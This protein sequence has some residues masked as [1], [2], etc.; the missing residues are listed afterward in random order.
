LVPGI[1]PWP[2]PFATIASVN[3]EAGSWVV[4][5]TTQAVNLEVA[6]KGGECRL[7][8]GT[9]T[10]AE[11]GEF[12][13]A[14]FPGAGA[15]QPVALTGATTA[16]GPTTAD[17]QCAAAEIANGHLVNPAVT[18]IRVGEVKTE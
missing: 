17:L 2:N 18:A 14:A 12:F 15:K 5:A 16:G 4:T 8:V 6:A 11:S 1:V 3:L 13:L 7:R 10:V 9:T